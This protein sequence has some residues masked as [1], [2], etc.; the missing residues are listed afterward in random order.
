MASEDSTPRSPSRRRL[1]ASLAA[2]PLSVMRPAPVTAAE[3]PWHHL[4]DGRF[5]NPLGS[6]VPGGTPA[7]WRGF[8]Y[9]RLLERAPPA[10]IPA[11]HVL[12]SGAALAG[13]AAADRA[14]S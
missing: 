9:R 4:P 5:R 6:P 12:G 11:G 14:D 7:D 3:R 2:T 10:P 8:F 1:L 13:L